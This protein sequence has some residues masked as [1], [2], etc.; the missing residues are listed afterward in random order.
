MSMY[1][2]FSF[3]HNFV[4]I[5]K[6]NF[7]FFVGL[8]D[9]MSKKFA[10]V[11]T[12]FIL[13]DK[14]N[15]MERRFFNKSKI[16]IFILLCTALVC[17][18][19]AHLFALNF[20][21]YADD[22]D[23][24]VSD[25]LPQSDLENVNLVNATAVY[26]GEDFTAIID[27]SYLFSLYFDNQVITVNQ[28]KNVLK[29]MLDVKLYDENTL[30]FSANA[31]LY[32]YD[33]VNNTYSKVSLNGSID[34]PVSY[35]DFNDNFLITSYQDT[36][37]VFAIE[38]QTFTS[39]ASGFGI[40]N[41][42]N[43]AINDNNELFHVGSNGI[44]KT[45]VSTSALQTE[46]NTLTGDTPSQIIA[47]NDFI[48]YVYDS[49]IYKL[50][51]NGGESIELNT[52]EDDSVY[53]LGNITAPKCISFRGDNLLVVQSNSIQEFEINDNELV[54]TGFA[55]AK[56]CTAYNRISSTASLIEKTGH[57]V[58]VLDDFKFTV[59]TNENENVYDRQNYLN[60]LC[61]ENIA[62]SG[63]MPTA[64]A[65]D[66]ENALFLY[67]SGSV[68]CSIKKL[69]IS[70]KEFID[71]DNQTENKKVRAI[72][73][74][75]GR[76][77]FLIDIGNDNSKVY[78]VLSS[79]TA[80]TED[81]L[82]FE[83]TLS[84]SYNQIAVDVYGNVILA[85]N[86]SLSVFNKQ[87]NY[88]RAWEKSGLTNLSKIQTDLVGRVFALDNGV[89]SYITSTEIKTYSSSSIKAFALDF[90]LDKTY[91]LC[92]N[93][94]F[95]S[96]TTDLDNVSFDDLIIPSTFTFTNVDGDAS[97]QETLQFFTLKQDANAYRVKDEQFVE[98]QSFKF[99]NLTNYSGEYVLICTV[100]CFDITEFYVL[101]NQTDIVLIEKTMAQ[102]KQVDVMPDVSQ[103][104]FIATDV[105]AYYLP[106][107]TANDNFVMNDGS[108]VIRLEKLTEIAPQHK[109]NFLGYDYYYAL[110][111]IDGTTRK[112]YIPCDYTVEILTE[113]LVFNEYRLEKVKECIVYSDETMATELARLSQ[114]SSVRVVSQSG[115]ICRVAY[116]TQSGEYQIGY[117]YQNVIINEPSI[118]IRNI[119]LIVII[120][121]CVCATSIYFILRK[122]KQD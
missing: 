25:F 5:K 68:N 49:K 28:D 85:T 76:F 94:E 12:N 53:D 21:A 91:L 113:D 60:F 33:L 79:S 119:L 66:G 109:I 86:T 40:S 37:K 120:V 98:G 41:G 62:S 27:D 112:V 104:A 116:K 87:N 32:S 84:N 93:S 118:A 107:I 105:N 58:A 71:F 77:Y 4:V 117:I 88:A 57:S 14:I 90:V 42:S 47:N 122:K 18:A 19:C 24:A 45:L 1:V 13:Y 59:F 48:Y 75:S 2:I 81:D 51:V 54:F 80:L 55:I 9:K 22:N 46:A 78:S 70:T 35:F 63:V 30:F 99:D 95:I 65:Y 44:Y 97:A 102:E 56:N 26:K 106:I 92:N 96:F 8:S 39:L 3:F 69:C 52:F 6:I 101:A 36:C 20:N 67:N 34:E 100:N 72:T 110:V 83:T 114:D 74:Q 115:E 7:Y 10:N 61:D 111:N 43:V 16:L 38:D 64:F 50:S 11:M 82:L 31:R 23:I 121:A 73:Y 108:N 17:F 15:S 89:L 103:K 29:D